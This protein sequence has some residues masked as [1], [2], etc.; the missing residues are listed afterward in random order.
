MAYLDAVRTGRG[1]DERLVGV[2]VHFRV[3]ITELVGVLVGGVIGAEIFD[4]TKVGF[5]NRRTDR[6]KVGAGKRLSIFQNE[7]Q[8]PCVH[9]LLGV[10]AAVTN[11][12][13][14]NTTKTLLAVG[15]I[16]GPRGRL[17][18]GIVDLDIAEVVGRAA[19][20]LNKR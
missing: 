17:V 10:K 12:H 14:A 9:D 20:S 4:A 15:K 1:V 11:D 18:V 2:Q 16:C 7:D 19:C 13:G 6:Q 3:G 8:T 5:N